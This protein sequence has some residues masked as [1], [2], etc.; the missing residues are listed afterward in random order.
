MFSVYFFTPDYVVG[1][2]S[3]HDVDSLN[4]NVWD[5]IGVNKISISL[6]APIM[7]KDIS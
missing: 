7:H 2:L 5:G 4:C 1:H 6:G 3:W